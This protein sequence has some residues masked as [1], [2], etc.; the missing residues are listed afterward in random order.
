VSSERIELI[1]GSG[2]IALSV[3]GGLLNGAP[4][5]PKKP[6]PVSGS[7]SE[8]IR[9]ALARPQGRPPLRQLVD[10]R[11]AGIIISDEF[12]AGLQ[13]Y[14]LEA[15]LE[16]VLA[17]NPQTVAVFCATGPHDPKIYGGNAARWVEEASRRFGRKIEFY[18]NDSGA[19]C[20]VDIGQ[21]SRGTPLQVNSFL[22]ESDV[23]IYGHEAK[24]HYF[25]GYSCVDKQILPGMS[26]N[27]SIARNHWW[28]LDEQS[29]PGRSPYLPPEEN[30]SNPVSEDAREARR[31]SELFVLSPSGKAVR[32]EVATFAL[33][34]VSEGQEI[35]WVQAGD[36]EE[37]NR[38]M[39]RVVDDLMAVRVAPA[40]YVILS[41]GGPPASQTLYST[42]NSFDLA[43]KGAI[44]PGGEA[45]VLA[46]LEGR[47]ELP[48]EVRGLAPSQKA[49]ELFWDN[50]VRLK[51]LPLRE[52][53]KWIAENF[54]LYMWKTERV[55]RLING[56]GVKIYLHS[57][58]PQETLRSG[59]LYAAPDPQSWIDERA[60]RGDGKFTIID[61]GN[62]LCVLPG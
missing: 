32:G 40:R 48:P 41:P 42:Q 61:N 26:S 38:R 1:Y 36:P 18:A 51:Q 45:L 31:I 33:D 8:I 22:L 49:K 16:E 15:L 35:Y 21:T 39:V 19:D 2:K 24:H 17:G 55:L 27:R 10:G 54:E 23:R 3:P 30:R 37:I 11:R 20:F 9:S 57:Q 50:V 47:P 13:K 12:R 62:K 56:L 59:G 43:L 53:Q 46:P 25:H 58:I 44:Q 60:A 7:I 14:I 52:A 28:A 4:L 29:G 6:A 5:G 34:M